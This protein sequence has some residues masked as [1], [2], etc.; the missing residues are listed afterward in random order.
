MNYGRHPR[1]PAIP[2]H[3]TTI[4]SANAFL[5][6][7]NT[8]LSWAKNALASATATMK[9]NADAQR[10]PLEFKEGDEVLLSSKYLHLKVNGTKKL[11]P[12]AVGPFTVLQKIGSFAYKL[13][14]TEAYSRIHPV[15][16]VSLLKLVNPD[17]AHPP[18]PLPTLEDGE[19][20]F[21]VEAIV[22]HRNGSVHPKSRRKN[23][24][25]PVK[26]VGYGPEHNS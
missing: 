18:P 9:R 10:R 20:E 23:Q 6:N 11:A 7:I 1:G 22:G 16:H 21:E 19:A 26:W 8:A 24:D 25:F 14:L 3:E 17:S 12:K 2:F 13:A 4:P 15:F 5:E